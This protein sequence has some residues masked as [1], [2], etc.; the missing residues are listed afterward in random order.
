MVKRLLTSLTTW[1]VAMACPNKR[2]SL[3]QNRS[4]VERRR[5]S[6]LAFVKLRPRPTR[7]T[8]R[9][10]AGTWSYA[11]LLSLSSMIAMRRCLPTDTRGPVK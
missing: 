10:M 5:R 3:L 9:W 11:L 2:A 1:T 7:M 6:T 4:L 8:S